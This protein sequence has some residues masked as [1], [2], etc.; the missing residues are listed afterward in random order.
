MQEKLLQRIVIKGKN[1]D[2][3]ISQINN[4]L[5]IVDIEGLIALGAPDDEYSS[6]A[7]YIFNAIT[8]LSVSEKTEA[9]IFAIISLLWIEQFSLSDTDVYQREPAIKHASK[10]I[11]AKL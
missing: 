6:E 2:I 1:M 4:I 8:K 3:T 10:S 5:Q 11:M 7:K 9:N